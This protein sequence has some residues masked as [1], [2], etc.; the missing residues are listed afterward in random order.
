MDYHY[1]IFFIPLALSLFFTPL[2]ISYAKRIGAIDQPN[3]RKVHKQ[4][5]P[6]LGGVA[7]YISFFLSL[8]IAM[9]LDPQ[10]NTLAGMSPRNGVMLV[11]SLTLVLF[12]GIWDDLKPL[13]P[14]KKFI[15]QVIAASIVY[16]AG[17]RITTITHPFSPNL[18][19]LGL[20][21]YPVTIL[22]IVGITNAFNLIDGLDGLAS[23]VALIVSIT[24][25]SISL[26][27]Q[28]ATTAMM[29]LLMAGALI[30]FLRYNFQGARI[31][32]GD[33]GSLF[34]GFMLAIL[35]MRSSTKG[36]TAFSIIV[37]VLAL[38]L[39]IMDTLLSM[40]RRFLKSVLPSSVLSSS[41]RSSTMLGKLSGIFHPDRGHIHHQ[42][43]E[44]GFSH[45]KVV[46]LLYVVSCLFGLGAFAVTFSNSF[47]ASLIIVSIAI[48]TFV[49]VSQ[50]RYR[51]MAI[52]R[53]GLFLPMYEWPLFQSS[54]FL[55]FLDLGFMVVSYLL[56][57]KLAFRDEPPLSN[58]GRPFFTALALMTGV[59][60]SMFYISGLYRHATRQFGLGDILKLVKGVLATVG[61]TYFI[62]LLLP[63][64]KALADAT[65]ILL[66]FF[67]LLSLVLAAR[68]SFRI[69]NYLSRR[70]G[71][72]E[73]TK[74]LIYGA[75]AN[76]LLLLHRFI[77]DDC[78]RYCPVGFLDDNPRL[79]GRRLD[80]Y[81]IF[82]GHWK[83]SR[84]V[85][86][87]HI[88]EVILAV[89]DLKP[90][91]LSRLHEI[92]RENGVVL[93]RSTIQLEEYAP[94]T[95]VKTLEPLTLQESP[96]LYAG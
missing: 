80:G 16:I 27:K 90:A 25:F 53:N 70:E 37:P 88:Q 86:T 20:F 6:R 7:I 40:I 46:L 15:A 73:C 22:W 45:R 96:G 84:L 57:Y 54:L 24:I 39:P 19:D 49:G 2:V 36:S 11:A 41:K 66:D 23:G 83:L 18:L 9:Y 35:S 50:L 62:L 94:R 87:K 48:A 34:I 17:F 85:R 4:P 33:S 51:E 78:L 32:L 91:I 67:M 42:L 5:I 29:A 14:G 55:S 81:P 59:Q 82:G 65:F 12:L 28:D 71:K 63:A 76:G 10:I 95:D 61:V 52:L 30:G 93:R 26:I 72:A 60:M 69:L 47:G 79:E 68:G 38:G 58:P 21:A 31:F 77:H 64:Q 74:V 3:E 1:F 43:I 92:C 56:S 8:V 44:R 13:S 89:G 75:D